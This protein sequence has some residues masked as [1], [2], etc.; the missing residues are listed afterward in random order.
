MESSQQ[1][2]NQSILYPSQ[3]YEWHWL[4][5][6][7]EQICD[8]ISDVLPLC[9][10]LVFADLKQK[11][12]LRRRGWW[13]CVMCASWEIKKRISKEIPLDKTE[14]QIP[15]LRGYDADLTNRN[16]FIN[17]PWHMGKKVETQERLN[18]LR[19]EIKEKREQG[20][21]RRE[22]WRE[23]ANS[24]WGKRG[25]EW[26]EGDVKGGGVGLE[27]RHEKWRDHLRCE[28]GRAKS[29]CWQQ[30]Q[31]IRRSLMSSEREG[32]KKKT[33]RRRE[34]ERALTGNVTPYWKCCCLCQ[35][36]CEIVFSSLLCI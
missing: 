23:Q 3:I 8:K 12:K 22:G 32:E 13:V 31:S 27:N 6:L 28:S 26:G 10:F 35:E 4:F 14:A 25:D 29:S 7:I 33:R 16:Q 19:D 17:I 5:G 20:G 36:L 24:E 1:A 11:Y 34:R 30:L 15:K 18:W 21:H 9:V 2:N